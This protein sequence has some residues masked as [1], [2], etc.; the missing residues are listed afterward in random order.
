MSADFTIRQ[1]DTKPYFSTVLTNPDGSVVDLTSATVSFTM[2]DQATK[3]RVITGS[4]TIV[5]PTLGQVQY[6]WAP[7]DTSVAGWYNGVFAV[8]FADT[9]RETFPN[10]HNNT[11]LVTPSV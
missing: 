4:C 1:G 10:D 3:L 2:R 8:T 6:H 11:V 5:A 7:G 9:S